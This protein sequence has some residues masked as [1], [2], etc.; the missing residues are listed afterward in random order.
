L[1]PLDTFPYDSAVLKRLDALL[2]LNISFADARAYPP[3]MATARM[4]A[5]VTMTGFYANLEKWRPAFLSILRIMIGLLFLQHG[6]S[7]Y[8]GFPA[9]APG[10]MSPLLYVQGIIEIVGG[11]LLTIGAFTRPVA[12]I[13]SGDMAVAYFMQHMPRSFFP[14]ANGG[15][16]AVLYC[17]V[18]FYIFLAGGGPWSLDR[19][20]LKQ[21]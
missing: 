2:P 7:K 17:F 4:R 13:L 12:F 10:S 1:C 8:L 5:E 11:A 15:N 20:V 18:F 3:T 21:E 6:L 16:L 9:A 19:T 14:A